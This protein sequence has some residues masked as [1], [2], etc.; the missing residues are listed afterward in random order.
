MTKIIVHSLRYGVKVTVQTSMEASPQEASSESRHSLSLTSDGSFV[1]ARSSLTS[2]LE[3]D[4]FVSLQN[5]N[6][7]GVEGVGTGGWS[8]EGVPSTSGWSKHRK[9][10]TTDLRP[11]LIPTKDE[12]DTAEAGGDNQPDYGDILPSQTLRPVTLLVPLKKKGGR[13]GSDSE[14]RPPVHP[15][16]GRMRSAPEVAS[17]GSSPYH[18]LY[19]H[20]NI[21]QK[22]QPTLTIGRGSFLDPKNSLK[23]VIPV[24]RMHSNGCV[25]AVVHRD[26]ARPRERKRRG[27]F[28]PAPKE[29][30]EGDESKLSTVSL[31]VHINGRISLSLTPLMLS[32]FDK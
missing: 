26:S 5:I 4:Q 10:P 2:F 12:P 23:L 11:L 27:R 19:S 32:F 31:G 29:D 9:K 14:L 13:A 18:R 16:I 30:G 17:A 28:S 24:L 6:E 25:P 15:A 7:A 20:T 22:S 1:S 21:D 8:L 3:E